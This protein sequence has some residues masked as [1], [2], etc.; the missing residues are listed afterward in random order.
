[1]PKLLIVDD[2]TDNRE[3]FAVILS[4]HGC[5]VL[6]AADSS[7]ADRQISD[8]LDLML[9]DLRLPRESGLD[10]CRRLKATPATA[11]I[12][13][14]LMSGDVTKEQLT[15]GVAAGAIDVMT[16]PF[17]RAE[18][19]ERVEAALAY[20]RASIAPASA[21]VLAAR[22]A[23]ALPS[24]NAQLLGYGLSLEPRVA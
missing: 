7:S 10:Y 15:A 14:L 11:G 21:A 8:D 3:L 23:R 4:T 1:M 2:D 12:P 17:G 24:R 9:L 19:V 16:K 22:A 5:H 20:S 18:L 6:T 13:I